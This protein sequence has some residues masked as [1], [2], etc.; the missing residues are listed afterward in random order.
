MLVRTKKEEGELV[1]PA[2]SRITHGLGGETVDQAMENP[3]TIDPSF[4]SFCVDWL[5]NPSLPVM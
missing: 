3:S 1:R 2:T 4:E 5:I